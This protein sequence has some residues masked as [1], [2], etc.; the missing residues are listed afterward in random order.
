[1]CEVRYCDGEVTQAASP[2][3]SR[4][5]RCVQST[6]GQRSLWRG[7]VK[8]DRERDVGLYVRCPYRMYV[9]TVCTVRKMSMVLELSCN[10]NTNKILQPRPRVYT[11][12]NGLLNSPSTKQNRTEHIRSF[13]SVHEIFRRTG[14]DSKHKFTR[15]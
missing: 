15:K 6:V 1:V 7:E 3:K 8:S 14:I 12:N 10:T 4:L 11:K 13:L 2:M 5:V 9:Q